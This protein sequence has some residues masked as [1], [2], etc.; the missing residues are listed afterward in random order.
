[1]IISC[2]TRFFVIAACTN[3]GDFDCLAAGP[4][5]VAGF[6]WSTELTWQS[7]D[8]LPA[9]RMWIHAGDSITWTFLTDEP[10]TVVFRKNGKYTS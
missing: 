5:A 6:S 4:C 8:S 9:Q 3:P 10:H 1:M 7:R 2:L